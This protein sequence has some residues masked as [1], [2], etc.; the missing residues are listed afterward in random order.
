MINIK[1]FFYFEDND[2]IFLNEVEMEKITAR[3][4]DNEIEYYII[5]HFS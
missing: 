1:Y 5:L 4:E 2:P 3:R